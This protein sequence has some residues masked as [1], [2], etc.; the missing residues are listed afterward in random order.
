MTT[1]K[2]N[3]ESYKVNAWCREQQLSGEFCEKT[4]FV[5]VPKKFSGSVELFVRDEACE[6][7][8][9]LGYEYFLF[10]NAVRC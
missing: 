3:M 4:I 5:N 1:T 2:E 8:I 10:G 9:Q 6:Q 7:L